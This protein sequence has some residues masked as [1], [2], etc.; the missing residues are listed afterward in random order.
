MSTSATVTVA[1]AAQKEAALDWDVWDST[2]HTFDKKS[3]PLGTGEFFFD[4]ADNY[5][6]RVIIIEGSATLTPT[7]D[8]DKIK[9]INIEAG[10]AVSF[11]QGF[12]CTWRV[13][14]PM[15]KHYAYFDKEGNKTVS[16]AISCDGEGCGI[17]CWTESY[18][19]EGDGLDLCVKCYEKGGYKGGEHQREGV[20]AVVEKPAKKKRKT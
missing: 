13:S 10:D 7:G 19:L 11:P 15:K 4:Y 14:A 6:E 3:S 17:D 12:S 16:N 9:I 20:A 8:G 1:T 2:T 5:E 18:F